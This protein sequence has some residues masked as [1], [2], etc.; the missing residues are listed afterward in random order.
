[1][2]APDVEWVETEL[3]GATPMVYQ[4]TETG[5]TVIWVLAPEEDDEHAGS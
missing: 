1:M 3:A 5:W 4:D 2:E